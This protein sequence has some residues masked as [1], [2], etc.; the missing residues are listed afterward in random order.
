MGEVDRD[1][2][3]LGA[4][5]DTLLETDGQVAAEIEKITRP[6]LQPAPGFPE[7]GEAPVGRPLET[8][9]L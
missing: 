3:L 6:H 1:G 2:Q 7:P 8:R 4:A 9:A 5:L